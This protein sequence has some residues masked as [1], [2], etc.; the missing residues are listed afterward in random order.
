MSNPNFAKTVNLTIDRMIKEKVIPPFTTFDITEEML[1]RYVEI[2]GSFGGGAGNKKFNYGYARKLAGLNILQ[3][4]FYKGAKAKDCKEGM[5][6][7][8]ANPVWPNHLKIGMTVDIDSRL[9]TYQTYDP[10]KRFYVKH[11]DFV[12]D[13]R[14]AEKKLLED[15]NIHLV[16]GEWV[17]YSDSL[18]IIKVIR[19]Y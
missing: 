19:R 3:M 5:V 9:D 15:F 10:Y 18:E 13:R 4:K 14:S 1:K 2:Y 6:Y 7:L 17:K 11:Y 12:L 16:D 8:I